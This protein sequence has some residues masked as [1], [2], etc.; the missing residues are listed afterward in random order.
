MYNPDDLKDYSIAKNK[1][2]NKEDTQIVKEK[3]K[4]I[5]N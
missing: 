4:V 1:E 3:S 2:V 5:I